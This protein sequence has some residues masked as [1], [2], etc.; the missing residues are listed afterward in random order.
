VGC[1]FNVQCEIMAL[2]GANSVPRNPSRI[3]VISSGIE[4]PG[5]SEQETTF[6]PSDAAWFQECGRCAT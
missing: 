6:L 5:F 2:A 4:K 1:V 3:A